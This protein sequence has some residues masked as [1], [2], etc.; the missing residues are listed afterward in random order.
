MRRTLVQTGLPLLLIVMVL[1]FVEHSV[2]RGL[3][4]WQTEE[5]DTSRLFHAGSPVPTSAIYGHMLLGGLITGLA[6]LQLIPALRRRLPHAHHVLGYG[7]AGLAAAT[8]VGGLVYIAAHGTI[9]GLPM[10][11]GFALYG[12]LMLIAAL[13][14][15]HHARRRDLRHR[16][17]AAR[18]VVLILGSYLYRVHYG[19]N[20]A[21]FGCVATT[22]EFTG[23]FDLIQNWAFY[24]PYLALLEI[25]LRR[26]RSHPEGLRAR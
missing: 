21:A 26:T 23:T 7:I 13:M 22:P 10:S 5:R 8:A 15:L 16:D 24:L 25:W 14:T 18:L 9:G 20:Y 2:G 11:L 6:P 4:L 1:W 17:W 12:T 3:S 19:I